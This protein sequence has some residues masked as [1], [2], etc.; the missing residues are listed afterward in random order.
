MTDPRPTIQEPTRRDEK[1]VALLQLNSLAAFH[2][3]SQKD[4]TLFARQ[5][6]LLIQGQV[7]LI[8]MIRSRGK[9]GRSKNGE[10]TFSSDYH[11]LR[12][13]DTG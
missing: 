3:V 7:V 4:V 10:P 8:V 13:G 9:Q 6:P 5:H 1:C 12:A 2:A 11:E